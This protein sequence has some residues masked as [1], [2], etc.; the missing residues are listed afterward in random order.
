[1]HI[2]RSK[3]IYAFVIFICLPLA[4]FL[5]AAN[6]QNSDGQSYTSFSTGT[7]GASLLYDSLKAMGYPVSHGYSLPDPDLSILDIHVFVEPN[8]YYFATTDLDGVLAWVFKGGRM[9]YLDSSSFSYIDEELYYRLGDPD[10]VSRGYTLY[11]YGLGEIISG[12]SDP[13]LNQALIDDSAPGAD[14]TALLDRWRTSPVIRFNESIHGFT[15]S[16]NAWYRTPEILKMLTYQIAVVAIL[17][18]WRLGKRFGRPLPYFEEIEREENEHVKA[19]A[20]IYRRAG[21]SAEALSAY[22]G[23]VI[24]YGKSHQHS[25]QNTKQNAKRVI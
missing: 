22:Q 12:S 18:L 20:N 3:I 15:D 1:M 6:S 23:N 9:I 16:G 19:L 24:L 5:F 21:V 2:K 13:L 4:V 14:F 17:I 10:A 7:D 25:L 11:S 8:Y